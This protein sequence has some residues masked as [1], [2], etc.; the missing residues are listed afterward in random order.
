MHSTIRTDDS[1]C[2]IQIRGYCSCNIVQIISWQETCGLLLSIQ[3][4]RFNSEIEVKGFK[5]RTRKFKRDE[6]LS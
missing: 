3:V 6:A 4:K 1:S 5:S 2:K